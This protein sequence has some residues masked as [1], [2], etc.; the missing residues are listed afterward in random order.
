MRNRLKK[1]Q[2]IIEGFNV[3]GVIISNTANIF[4]LTGYSNFSSEERE[5]YL[6]ITSKK[7]YLL[8][9]GRY[10]EAVKK[11]IL[12]FDNLEITGKLSYQDALKNLC[13]KHNIQS[14]GIEEDSLTVSEYKKI[15]KIFKKVNGVELNNLRLTKEEI[16][17]KNIKSACNIADQAVKYILSKLKTGITEKE[18]AWE[19]EKFVKENGGKLSFD[20]I[21]AFGENSSIPHHQTG[22]RKLKKGD[23]ILIDCGS[24]V[25]GYCSDMTRTYIFG[26]PSEKQKKIHKA[27]LD[28]QQKAINYIKNTLIE[29]GRVEGSDVDRVARVY[30]QEQGF[31]P[32]SHGLGHGTGILIHESPI[33]SSKSK[34]ILKDGMI[35]SIEPGIYIPGFGGVR[36]EDLFVIKDNKLVQ[37]TSSPKE[38][39]EL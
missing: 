18:V 29:G 17:I 33:L 6:L 35:F 21:I 25:N 15:K 26:S 27:V 24:K 9:D 1:L 2:E 3:D 32:Y 28:S 36:I 4:Y 37:F 31:E 11:T 23:F 16:E 12:H 8:T 39:I 30:I 14:L 34:D 20:T 19:F 10:I 22:R 38:L 13:K 5:C 7:Q